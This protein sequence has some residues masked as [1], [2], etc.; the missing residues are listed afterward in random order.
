VFSNKESDHLKIH[1]L[2]HIPHDKNPVEIYYDIKISSGC[3]SFW[4]GNC[5]GII[6]S[7]ISGISGHYP[8]CGLLATFILQTGIF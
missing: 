1:Q 7:L 3:I 5:C 4:L 6:F 2:H 8:N